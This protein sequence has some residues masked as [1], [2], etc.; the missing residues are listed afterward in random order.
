MEREEFKKIV[1]A[2]NAV[3][4]GDN[5]IPTQT[6][7]DMWYE[8]LK[9][10]SYQQATFAAQKYIQTNHFP[11]RPADLRAIVAEAE[12]GTKDYGD[13]WEEVTTAIRRYGYMRE[14]EALASMDELT[15]RAVQNMG[16][17]NLCM[18]ESPMTDR[19]NFRTIYETLAK[20]SRER[21]VVSPAIQAAMDRM[22]I[23]GKGAPALEVTA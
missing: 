10:L 15:R 3:Y 2:L 5:F 23:E 8:A 17:Q 21:A 7:F 14:R 20:R 4:V 18:S 9:D 13:A 1:M 16:Y 11:P 12:D 22:R 19:A 6:A